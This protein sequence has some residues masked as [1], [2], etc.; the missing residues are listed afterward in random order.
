MTSQDL[1]RASGFVV[2]ADQGQPFWFPS[3][4]TITKVG[5]GHSHGQLSIVDHRVPPG[6]APPLHLH[7]HSDEALL[8][9]HPA[10]R[11]PRH[12]DPAPARTVTT[13]RQASANLPRA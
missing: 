4:L 3:T 1:T 8:V 13:P 5:T 12:P 7:R 10:G 9:P 6:F 2:A 11:R